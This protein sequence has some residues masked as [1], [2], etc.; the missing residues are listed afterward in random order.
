MT[1]M[2]NVTVDCA[3][4]ELL[5][6]FWAGALGFREADPPDGFATWEDWLRHNNVPEAEWNDGAA[7]EDP[8]G[9]LPEIGFLKVPEGKTV[10][11]RW[12][13]DL[14]VSGGRAQPPELRTERIEA[15]AAALIAAGAAELRR[16]TNNGHL[17]AITMADPEGNEFCLV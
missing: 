11:N 4:P 2:W 8:D 1:T 10:K 9:V 15:R 5:A 14:R 17:D 7:I 16:G 3:D 6:R 12:H 13:L